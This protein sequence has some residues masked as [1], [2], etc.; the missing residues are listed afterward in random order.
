MASFLKVP[1]T[2]HPKA[3][4]IDVFDCFTFVLPLL[5]R[6]PREHPHKTYIARN[7]VGAPMSE[8]PKLTNCVV[9]LKLTE[10]IWPRYINITD[11]QTEDEGFTVA[12]PRNT[13]C[14][15]R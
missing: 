8:D 7:G 5:F 15:A 2:Q 1:K 13:Q 3:L 12:I 11:G 6:E 4:K 14:I 10:L 9:T